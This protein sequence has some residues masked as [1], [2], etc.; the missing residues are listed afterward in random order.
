LILL[1]R[2]LFAKRNLNTAQFLDKE[3]KQDEICHN[4]AGDDNGYECL[5]LIHVF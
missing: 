5:L 3:N 2:G 4:K 1:R